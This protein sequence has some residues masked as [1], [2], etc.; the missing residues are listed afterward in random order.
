MRRKK[1]SEPPVYEQGL[2]ET[3]LDPPPKWSVNAFKFEFQFKSMK[4]QLEPINKILIIHFSY[5]FFLQ[6]SFSVDS[7]KQTARS[8]QSATTKGSFVSTIVHKHTMCKLVSLT[9]KKS[10]ISELLNLR[11]QLKFTVSSMR[12]NLKIVVNLQYIN[13]VKTQ[14]QNLSFSTFE[15]L[16]FT[17]VIQKNREIFNFTHEKKKLFKQ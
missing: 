8:T 17:K 1:I 9:K 10:E 3:T 15:H 16:C 12:K 2:N 11:S 6:I 14:R 13:V 4:L 7:K 5:A